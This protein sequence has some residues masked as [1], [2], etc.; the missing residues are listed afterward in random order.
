MGSP[1]TPLDS[2]RFEALPRL[3]QHYIGQ[4]SW[5]KDAE[6]GTSGSA[7][8]ETRSEPSR[9][10]ARSIRSSASPLMPVDLLIP[11][12]SS[13]VAC[14][15]RRPL[16][17]LPLLDEA[18]HAHQDGPRWSPDHGAFRSIGFTTAQFPQQG[19]SSYRDNCQVSRAKAT[20]LLIRSISRSPAAVG[21]PPNLFGPSA[22][23]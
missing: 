9:K 3:I 21:Y 19:E 10:I 18:A 12:Y 7:S 13:L 23:T 5:S 22:V 11:E 17:A 1:E 2:E 4:G 6:S 14:G 20:T 15:S 8:K 16:R